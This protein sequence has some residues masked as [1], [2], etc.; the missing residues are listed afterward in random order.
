MIDFINLLLF[1]VN[2]AGIVF[3]KNMI[4]D[5]HTLL[6]KFTI[7]VNVKQLK[8]IYLLPIIKLNVSSQRNYFANRQRSSNIWKR[9]QN[10]NDCKIHLISSIC[11]SHSLEVS[12]V[13]QSPPKQVLMCGVTS[14]C[15][16][17]V[18]WGASVCVAILYMIALLSVM[19]RIVYF[20]LAHCIYIGLMLF[21]YQKWINE[22]WKM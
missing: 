2:Y 11:V 10:R 12:W 1:K 20:V 15:A 19:C 5:I 14:V 13:L 16:T 3:A 21:D 9:A 17:F 7:I 6:I 22:H 18:Q 4:A 8:L